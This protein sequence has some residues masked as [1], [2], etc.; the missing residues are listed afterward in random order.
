MIPQKY[1]ISE[2]LFHELKTTLIDWRDA[3]KDHS[4]LFIILHQNR[5]E[6]YKEGFLKNIS[7]MLKQNSFQILKWRFKRLTSVLIESPKNK[8]TGSKKRSKFKKISSS[9]LILIAFKFSAN[10]SSFFKSQDT[11][12]DSATSIFTLK[13]FYRF[14]AR[15]VNNYIK[16]AIGIGVADIQH[17]WFPQSK[18]SCMLKVERP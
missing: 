8:R 1:P 15:I 6:K 2:K 5:V 16:C 10:R 17:V 11:L 7:P 18:R 12:N 4:V 13:S 14:N 3:F 9:L